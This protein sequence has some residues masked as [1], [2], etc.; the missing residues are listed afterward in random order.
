MQLEIPSSKPYGLTISMG[1][2]DKSVVSCVFR[3][4]G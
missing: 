2:N 1:G 4:A 3:R